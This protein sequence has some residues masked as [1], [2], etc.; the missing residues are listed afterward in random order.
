MAALTRVLDLYIPSMNVPWPFT[1]DGEPGGITVEVTNGNLS[2]RNTL[3]VQILVNGEAIGRRDTIVGTLAAGRIIAVGDALYR[4]ATNFDW[5]AQQP[6]PDNINGRA[7]MR[8]VEALPT[9]GPAQ[10]VPVRLLGRDNLPARW[11]RLVDETV[12]D[13]VQSTG[14]GADVSVEVAPETVAVWEV[15]DPA[16]SITSDALLVDEF[17]GIWAVQGLT[18]NPASDTRALLTARLQP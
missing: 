16:R 10:F 9:P 18:R 12:A 3:L 17:G 6:P 15:N 11:A 8:L 14:S 2:D 7:V 4:L 13:T 1:V 5:T